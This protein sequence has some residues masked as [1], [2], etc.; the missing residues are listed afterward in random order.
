MSSLIAPVVDG[1][2]Q[3]TTASSTS[4]ASS[5]DDTGGS[6][7]SDTF[8]TLLVA[9]M[10]NQDPLEPTSNTEW[11]SQYATFTQ[12]EQMTE[13]CEAMDTMRA[14]DL[15]G[16]EVIM[17]VT[18]DS[19]DTTYVRGVVDYVVIEN[20]EP[21]LVINEEKYS[22]DDLDTVASDE[23]FAKY[24]KYVEFTGMID[25]L[26]TLANTDS[27]YADVIGEIYELYTG[28]TEEEL[29][30]LNTFASGYITSYE[31]YIDRME[32]LGVTYE[33]EEETETTLDD[34]ISSFTTKM[35]EMISQLTSQS[36]T[37]ETIASASSTST[38]SSSSE[39]TS[40]ETTDEATDE[41][42]STETVEE[43]TSSDTTSEDTDSEEESQEETSTTTDIA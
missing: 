31:A 11:V 36:S 6:I 34:V 10:Q 23:Y 43:T 16:K 24:D 30:Y 33:T 21:Y 40:D 32:E 2:I 15:V 1:V 3:T 20:G 14:N 25:A 13:M 28:M 37:L 22:I 18:S 41:T 17:E 12:V 27:S 39:E 9:E 29:E 19:G 42:T 4:L 26:P 7:T 8:L 35:D 5:E 38:E